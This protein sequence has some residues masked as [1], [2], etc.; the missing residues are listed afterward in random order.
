[1]DSN[2]L[3]E[4]QTMHPMSRLRFFSNVGHDLERYKDSISALRNLVAELR[5]VGDEAVQDFVYIVLESSW[6]QRRTVLSEENMIYATEVRVLN[7]FM[8]HTRHCLC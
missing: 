7:Y 1:M 5:R 8:T 4:G 3:A 6:K 2:Y